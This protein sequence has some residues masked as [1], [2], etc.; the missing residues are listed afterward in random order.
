M[1]YTYEEAKTKIKVTRAQGGQY[2]TNIV[3][4]ILSHVAQE[5]GD[6]KANQLIR[7]CHLEKD[8][9]REEGK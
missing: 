2:W 6:D 3:G 7:E 4:L 8:G 1:E 5:L 9:W